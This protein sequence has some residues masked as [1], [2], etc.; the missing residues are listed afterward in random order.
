MDF[1]LP[2]EI[3]MLRKTVREFV[4]KRLLPISMQVEEEDKIPDEIV[5]EMK[6]MGFF[7]LPFPEEYDGVGMGELGYVVALEEL[8]AANAAFGNLI[9]AHTGIAGMSIYLDGTPEQKQKYIPPMA[10]GEMIGAFALTEPNAGSDAAAIETTARREGDK[11]ILNGSKMW[12]TNGPIANVIIVFAVTDKTLGARGGISAFIVENTFP[13]YRVGKVDKKMGLHGS[14]TSELIFEDCVVPA[15]NLLGKPGLGF[16]TAMKALDMGR[17]GLAAGAV[18]AAQ[19]ALEMSIQWANQRVQF[20]KPI[21]EQQA[22]QWMLA[23]MATEIHAARLMTYHAAYKADRGE[24]VSREAAMVKMFASEMACR[25]VDK[26]VQIHGGT[27]YMAEHPVERMY[28]DARI[29]KI[30]EGTNEI[31]RL[32]IARDLLKAG[33]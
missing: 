14:Y 21:G 32:V 5:D 2:E 3:E 17:I 23:E 31:Q 6:D 25:V 10:R 18:G 28:R 4:E 20:G 15:E 16:V 30:Y 12:I 1:T 22:I 7:G 33:K 27:G 24:R 26:A 8:G 19:K 9:G 13:G 29:L 11:Y